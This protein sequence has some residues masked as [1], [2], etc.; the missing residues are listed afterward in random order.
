VQREAA[1]EVK[2]ANMDDVPESKPKKVKGM[3]TER[4]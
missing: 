4:E 1:A 2:D 3:D